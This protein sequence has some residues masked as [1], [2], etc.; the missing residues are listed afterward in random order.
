[1]VLETY[2]SVGG[3]TRVKATVSIAL[4]FSLVLHETM[5]DYLIKSRR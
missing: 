1:M 3:V 4:Q 5:V 2:E